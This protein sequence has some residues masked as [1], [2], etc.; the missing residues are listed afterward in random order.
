VET[1][2]NVLVGMD[3]SQIL[4]QVE[5]GEMIESHHP[6]IFGNAKAA[7]RIIGHLK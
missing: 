7:E 6:D 4:A 1:G 5:D 2:W 3:K